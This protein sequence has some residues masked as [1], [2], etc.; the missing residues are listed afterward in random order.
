MI[1]ELINPKTEEYKSLKEV[2]FSQDF[3]WYWNHDSVKD[4]NGDDYEDMIPFFNHTLIKRP[5]DPP[6]YPIYPKV[7]SGYADIVGL[8]VK[9][10]MQ[11]NEIKLNCV[12]RA[13]FNLTLPLVKHKKIRAHVD[14]YF[15][16]KNLL[17]YL[18]DSDGDTVLC[19]DDDNDIDYSKPQEDK[20]ILFEGRHYHYLPEIS[21]RLIFICTFI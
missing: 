6:D 16:H 2:I 20:I 8:V 11:V 3:P 18:N 15:P 14:H 7:N 9:Q 1:E 4:T 13:S 17:I 21:R 5:L 12:Y 19:D 10:I